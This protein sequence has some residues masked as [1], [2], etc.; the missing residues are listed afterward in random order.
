MPKRQEPSRQ[1]QAFLSL[2]DPQYA[3]FQPQSPIQSQLERTKGTQDHRRQSGRK[4][5]D[6]KG[7]I[8]G[9]QLRDAVPSRPADQYLQTAQQLQAVFEGTWDFETVQ[10]V[11][12]ECQGSASAATDILLDLSASTQPALPSA[13]AHPAS[14]AE[15]TG[16]C[17]LVQFWYTV[18]A[19]TA[20]A[21]R[22]I[23][24]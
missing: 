22:R 1:Q 12:T 3:G 11:V 4:Q 17:A 9:F 24:L 10:Q 2:I 20:S 5:Q 14:S 15:P 13:S 23:C 7:R 21:T 18:S 16:T 8:P 6:N 19:R